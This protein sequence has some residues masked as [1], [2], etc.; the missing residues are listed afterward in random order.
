M[1]NT[2]ALS[3]TS[4]FSFVFATTVVELFLEFPFFFV[5]YDYD[6]TILIS[7]EFETTFDMSSFIVVGAFESRL[8]STNC[9]LR[10]IGHS[11]I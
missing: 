3:T 10:M 1:T 8:V 6:P 4:S 9:C 7:N 11:S 2:E 5:D